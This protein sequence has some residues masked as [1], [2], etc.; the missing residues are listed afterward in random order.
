MENHRDANFADMY[1]H[2]QEFDYNIETLFELIDASGLE[3]VGFSNPSY[4]DLDRLIGSDPD[5]QARAA[6]L[7]DRERY[8][9]IELL[10]PELS[11][12][13]FFLARPPF[14]PTD[15]SDD[16]TLR[17]AT[18]SL[19]PCLQ[20]W[21]SPSLFDLNYQ[22]VS[23]D[24]SEFQFMQACET[25]DRTI[26]AILTEIAITPDQIRELVKRQLILLTP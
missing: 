18:P 21:P 4:W 15:W 2:P 3:F 9:L 7:S 5:L 23:L 10:D 13:E 24:D 12:Y 16:D 19:S 14:T 11:H 22:I 1:V 6:K 8:R 20:G 26:G 17:R 25:G